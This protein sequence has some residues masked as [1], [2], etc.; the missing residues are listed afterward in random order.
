MTSDGPSHASPVAS[1]AHVA[2]APGRIVRNISVATRL[3]LVVL[4]VALISLVITSIIGLSRGGELADDV[5]SGRITALGAAR[6]DEVER[7]VGSL[8]RA[9]I[10]QAISP[11]TAAAIDQFAEAYVELQAEEPS[12]TDAVAV[13]DYYR[14]TVA[15]ELTAARGR[16]VSPASLVPRDPA[17]VH[18][19]AN[20]VVP[21]DGDGGVLTD[22][23]E[24]SRWSELHNSLHQS[25]NEFTIQTGV[26]DF[27][28]IEADAGIIVYSTAKDI[29][30]ATSLLTGPQSGSALAVL[31]NSFGNQPEPGV[32]VIRDFAGYA[33]AGDE[34]SLFVA[35]PVITNGTLIGFVAIRIGPNQISSITTNDGSWT[36]EGD[37]AETYVVARDDLMRSD[38]RGFIEDQELYLA[39]VSTEG[40]ATEDQIRWMETFGTTVLFQ[41]VANQDVDAALDDEPSLVETTSYLG[42]EVLQARRALDI[43]GLDWA[44][45]TEVGRQEL[46]QPIVDFARNLL[47][48]IALFLV[49]ITFLAVR[50]SNTLLAPLRIISGKLRAVRAGGGIE[51]GA[52]SSALPDGSP[53]EFVD[54]AD[55]IDTMLETLAARNADAAERAAERRQL[56]RRILPPQAAQ[57]AEAGERN[58]VDQV[59]HATAAVVVIRGLGPLM[60][61]G[62][63][64][65]ARMLLDRFVEETDALARQRGLERIRLTGHAYF[66]TCGTV[67]PHIDHAARAVA[68]VLDVRDLVRDLGDD[69]RV[70]SMSAGV[71]SGPVTVGLTGGSGLVY[72]AWGST[73]QR[74]TDLAWQAASNTLLV[75]AAVRSQLPS[76]FVTD[77]DVGSIDA[78]GTTILSGR[79]SDG[80]PVR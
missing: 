78:H 1:A 7:Y 41:P 49:A 64:D 10:A 13:D 42:A 18:L 77:D 36:L 3:S 70:I 57:R 32:A 30:F 33:A 22:A 26:D 48:S 60:R 29:D 27:Y 11:S 40:T 76:R 17:A 74:A 66:A 21:S 58:V 37:T 62:S 50:W 51:V 47:I 53:T 24:G 59:A 12:T 16:P 25:F 63:K 72:D 55:D 20:Y 35:S 79:A 65:E 44:M 71:D 2:S 23:G 73:V 46:E 68:F 67:R 45:V 38:A 61:A 14:D 4:L 56:L 43:E 75:S 31:V 54:L 34:P 80:E 52:S 5:L 8:E 28:L 19:Q 15:P 6:A 9:A 39:S 69:D